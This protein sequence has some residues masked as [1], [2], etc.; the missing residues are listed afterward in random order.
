MC[1][2]LAPLLQAG[3]I[4]AHAEAVCD[5]PG[6][7]VFAEVPLMLSVEINESLFALDP[8]TVFMN[9]LRPSSAIKGSFLWRAMRRRRIVLA[10]PPL[11]VLVTG[12][13][14]CVVVCKLLHRDV[15]II[16]LPMY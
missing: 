9:G 6:L 11:P 10:L 2:F 16:L 3:L 8:G 1:A 7:G 14:S 4:R 13:V 15:P 5:L 12:R